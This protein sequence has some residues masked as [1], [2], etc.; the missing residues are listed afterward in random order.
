[1]PNED[2]LGGI[3]RYGEGALGVALGDA[4]SLACAL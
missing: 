2:H 4:R 1:V 3:G